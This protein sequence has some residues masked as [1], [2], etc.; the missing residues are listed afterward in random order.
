VIY[1]IEKTKVVSEFNYLTLIEQIRRLAEFLIYA[2][3]FQKN[4]FELFIEIN[5]LEHFT[6]FLFQG[7]RNVNIQLIQTMSIL[8]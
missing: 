7:N 6:R 5:I 1:E 8:I 3:K 4:Y 2:E